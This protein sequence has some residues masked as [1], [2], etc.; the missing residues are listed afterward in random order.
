MDPAEQR[1]DVAKERDNAFVVV[2]VKEQDWRLLEYRLSTNS[3]QTTRINIDRDRFPNKRRRRI[4]ILIH[5]G[6]LIGLCLAGYQSAS[7]DADHMAGLAHLRRLD[8]PIPANRFLSRLR[9]PFR[10]DIAEALQRGRLL[11]RRET[12]EVKEEL[13]RDALHLVLLEELHGLIEEIPRVESDA[14]RSRAEQ[15][16]AIA[17]ALESVTLNSAKALPRTE[18]DDGPNLLPFINDMRTH[19]PDEA[20]IIRH[21]WSRMPD[22]VLRNHPKDHMAW[23]T[24]A[25]PESGKERV[26]IAYADK[27]KLENVTGTDLIY[28]R[29]H[30]PGFVLIQYKRMKSEPRGDVYRPDAQLRKQIMRMRNIVPTDPEW[31]HTVD[32]YR[33]TPEPFFI[34]VVDPQVTRHENY[35]LADGMYFPLRLF[36]SMLSSD[37]HLGPQD[38][39]A[40]GR[41][42]APKH[43]S[44]DLFIQLLKNGWIGTAGN[45]T[46]AMTKLIGTLLGEQH[47]LVIAYDLRDPKDRRGGAM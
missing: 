14:T 5:D 18:H 10:A 3:D 36:E 34:K 26:S 39:T 17:L 30:Q 11:D 47:G 45:D 28:F 38:G 23:M 6:R 7:G 32:D 22:W 21:D 2:I 37:E 41:R 8:P 46:D 13:S 42:N 40:I 1:W 9:E 44:N 12:H 31:L 25:D 35:R 27:T 20:A 43:L 33:I 15:R 29:Q 16:D 4:C 19:P 24:F